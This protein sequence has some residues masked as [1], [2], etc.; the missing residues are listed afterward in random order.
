M[1]ALSVRGLTVLRARRTA[2]EDVSFSAAAGAIT[3][4]LGDSGA[5]KTSLLAA[6]AGLLPAERGA[7]FSDGADV[8][9]LPPRRRGI[10]L[11]PPGTALPGART[12]EAAVTRLAGRAG[13]DEAA[14]LMATLAPD[15]AATPPET[16]SHGQAQLALAAARLLRPGAVLLIDEA[17]MGLDEPSRAAFAAHLRRLAQAGRAVV[18]ATRDPAIARLSDHLV[19]L[20][21]GRAIQAGTPASL[22]A[23]PCGA[24]AARLTGPANIL[25]GRIRELRGQAFVWAA[26]ARFL[27]AVEPDMP[28][29]A[30]GAEVTICLRPERLALLAN[31]ETADNLLDAEITDVRAA[32]PLLHVTARTALG[33]LLAAV[34]SWRPAFYP[35]PGQTLRLAW[36]PDAAWILP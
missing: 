20:A 15:L 22:Y 6:I 23:E 4:I 32:G 3:A 7:V 11:L 9:S 30:L 8:T 29:P 17:G 21:G 35:T 24:V 33:D 26:G 19:L 13:R 28:R 27:Q 5:G 1:T 25:A 34:P 10:G 2:L 14:T 16:L 18:I 12:V 36:L 31:D